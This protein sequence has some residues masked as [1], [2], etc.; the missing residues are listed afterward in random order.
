MSAKVLI[1]ILILCNSVIFAT[2]TG[3]SYPGLPDNC[4]EFVGIVVSVTAD[5]LEGQ[6]VQLYIVYYVVR[7][8]YRNGV[9]M[10]DVGAKVQVLA[11]YIGQF[12]YPARG[13]SIYQGISWEAL[14][15][16]KN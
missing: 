2:D 9:I 16:N 12:P 11:V 8:W 14:H 4:D 15:G 5:P 13:V 10:P 6:W 3:I 1:C 7:V